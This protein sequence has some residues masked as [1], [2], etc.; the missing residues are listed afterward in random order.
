MKRIRRLAAARCGRIERVFRRGDGT[1]GSAL[2]LAL[3]TIVLLSSLIASFLFRVHV[4]SD[5]AIRHRFGF[6][7][8]ALSRSGVDMAAWL[9]ATAPDA[10]NEPDEDQTEEQ[11]IAAK[12][13]QVGI[14]V[15]NYIVE[16][17]EGQL[18]LSIEPE[19][20]RRN[21]NELSDADWELILETAGLPEENIDD[22]IDCFR[23]WTDED[24]ATRLR[25]AEEV[26]AYYEDRNLPVKNGPVDHLDELLLIKGFTPALL[27]GGNLEEFYEEPDLMVSGIAPL[28]TVYG[29]D[30]IQVNAA[31]REVLMSISGIR[32]DQVDRLL[33]GRLGRDGIEGTEDDGFTSAADAILAGGITAD[34]EGLFTTEGLGIVRVTSI[35]EVSGVARTTEAILEINGRDMFILSTKEF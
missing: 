26:D 19:S 11:F 1:A 22:L 6:K 34:A 13:L 21:V 7:A 10:G 35:G 31:S 16:T 32:E 27:Y 8:R 17:E 12:H 23:D 30:Q 20:G 28:L 14:A 4:E 18:R 29:S 2:M 33:E 15:R 5:L 24:D 25:G 3:V 9:L